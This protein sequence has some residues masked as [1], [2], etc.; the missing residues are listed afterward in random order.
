MGI[1]KQNKKTLKLKIPLSLLPLNQESKGSTS[2]NKSTVMSLKTL[3]KG[4]K[5]DRG[6]LEKQDSGCLH[7]F[8]EGVTLHRNLTSFV[9]LTHFSPLAPKGHT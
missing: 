2:Q 4:L 5:G 9:T 1:K 6:Q 7:V 8:W 3:S